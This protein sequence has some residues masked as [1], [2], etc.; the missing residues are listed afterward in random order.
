ME[1]QVGVKVGLDVRV[2]LAEGEE[3]LVGEFVNVGKAVELGVAVN[4]RANTSLSASSGSKRAVLV[5]ASR[6]PVC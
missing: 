3:V 2:G 5:I 4:P 6:V 1:V